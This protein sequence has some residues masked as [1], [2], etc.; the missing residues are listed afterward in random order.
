MQRITAVLTAAAL[1][2]GVVACGSDDEPAQNAGNG[3]AKAGNETRTIGVA[4]FT[5]G[6][7]YFIGMSKAVQVAASE[8]GNVQVKVTDANGDGA[9]LTTDVQNLVS[10]KVDGIIISAGP[11][12]AAPAALK[13]AEDAGIPV[14]MVDRKLTGDNYTSW[15]GPDNKAIGIQDGEYINEKLGEKGGKVAIIRGGPADN[16][17]GLDR[18]EGMKSVISQNPNIEIITAPDFGDWGTDGGV[19]VTENLLA[20]HKDLDVI[21]CE[22]DSMCLGAQKA[23]GDAGLSD[24]IFLAGVDGQKEALKAILDGTNYEVTGKNDADEI[25][26]KGFERMMEILDGKQVEKD[27]V[28]PSP[29]ITKDNAEEFYDPNSIF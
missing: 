17:I 25:G 2:V 29:R 3:A 15:I 27:T 14:V 21:F 6:A 28:V 26:R 24:Q 12:A 5:L 8:R 1:A 23:V 11:L 18:T 10:Q 13:A 22:N 20:K 4:N 16:T 7:A 9:K 19:K